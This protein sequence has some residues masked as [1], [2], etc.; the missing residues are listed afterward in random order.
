[1]RGF[2]AT[3][4][5]LAA[6]LIAA[7][8]LA[9]A[10]PPFLTGDP[11]TVDAHH[12]EFSVGAWSE[13]RAGQRVDALPA[14]EARGGAHGW[15]YGTFVKREI[16]HGHAIGIELNGSSAGGSG[17]SRL[18]LNLGAQI[19]LVEWGKLLAGIGREL[20]DSDAPKLT[21]RAYLG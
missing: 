13:R 14:F 6:T 10:G 12:W 1:M 20:H 17:G 3:A 11:D 2:P 5:A 21:S 7:S 19:Q 9:H 8:P 16:E 15:E 18:S 4:R